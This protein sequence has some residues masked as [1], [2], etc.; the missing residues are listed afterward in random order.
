MFIF[1][2]SKTNA[3]LS[4]AIAIGSFSYRSKSDALICQ[5]FAVFVFGFFTKY[6][7]LKLPMLTLLPTLCSIYLQ[8]P[9]LHARYDIG[10]SEKK[11]SVGIKELHWSS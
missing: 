8:L 7:D 3:A 2:V 4:G 6:I 11:M 5:W 1:S 10:K 9:S